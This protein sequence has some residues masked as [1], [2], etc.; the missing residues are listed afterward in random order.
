MSAAVQAGVTTAQLDAVCARVLAQH[1]AKAAPKKV[2][3]FPG[4]ACISVNDEV[5]HGVPGERVLLDGDLVKLDV[6]AEKNGFFA[7]AAVTARV[8]EVSATADA[9]ARCAENAFRQAMRVARAGSRV[10]EIGRAV[11]REVRR[12]GFSVLREYCGH[13]VGRTIHEYRAQLSGLER[14]R[15]ADRG[16]GTRHRADHRGRW[17]TDGSGPLDG[18][19]RRSK[20]GSP[21]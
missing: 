13:G 1:Q 21:L 17:R 16:F 10:Y 14:S 19:H 5:V 11:E 15:P 18:P 6:T 12:S 4:T 9:L 7:D 20:P 3:G 2:Y 8:G